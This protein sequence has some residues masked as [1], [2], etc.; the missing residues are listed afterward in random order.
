MSALGQTRK[1]RACPLGVRFTPLSGRTMRQ[2]APSSARPC[3]DLRGNTD[4]SWS[5]SLTYLVKNSLLPV[6]TR[7]SR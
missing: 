2:V 7:A 4:N 5:R 1:I 6:D 3:V